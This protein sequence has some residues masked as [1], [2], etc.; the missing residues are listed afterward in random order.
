MVL[1]KDSKHKTIKQNSSRS[2]G[3]EG[4]SVVILFSMMFVANSKKGDVVSTTTRCYSPLGRS[5]GF[6][7]FV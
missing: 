7:C 4:Y 2:W 3:L 5:D 6:L 1:N